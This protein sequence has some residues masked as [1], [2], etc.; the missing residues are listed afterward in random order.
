[1]LALPKASVNWTAPSNVK[2][3]V[4]ATKAAITRRRRAASDARLAAEF[5][6]R[7][8]EFLAHLDRVAA[9]AKGGN[10]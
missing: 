7:R 9:A 4:Y 8:I 6:Q 1:M 5:A 2:L 3:D 10:A